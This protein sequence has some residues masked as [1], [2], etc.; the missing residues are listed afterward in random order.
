MV[1]C[2]VDPRRKRESTP[3]IP[4]RHTHAETIEMSDL[5]LVGEIAALTL[6]VR[7]LLARLPQS[8]QN[9]IRRFV[10]G[11]LPSAEVADNVPGEFLEGAR[12]GVEAVFTAA[13]PESAT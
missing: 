13:T 4:T 11:R 8:E 12:N 9:E 6:V 5:K 3:V 10:E 2:G 1:E 7:Q